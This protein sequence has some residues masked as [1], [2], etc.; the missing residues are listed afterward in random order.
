MLYEDCYIGRNN[1]LGSIFL[2]LFLNTWAIKI[3]RMFHYI[4]R[5]SHTCIIVINLFVLKRLSAL[6]QQN[7]PC[8]VH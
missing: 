8:C 2:L 5:G 1:F 3:A 4:L 6:Q 7:K